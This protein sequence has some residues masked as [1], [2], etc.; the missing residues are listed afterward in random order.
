MA[1]PSA[2]TFADLL[3]LRTDADL[4]PAHSRVRA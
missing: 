4:T 1:E 2:A 3:R